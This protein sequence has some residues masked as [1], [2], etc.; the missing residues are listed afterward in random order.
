[1]KAR[2]FTDFFPVA[3]GPAPGCKSRT[4]GPGQ[5][6][7]NAGQGRASIRSFSIAAAKSQ[8]VDHGS[9]AG[10]LSA[11]FSLFHPSRPAGALNTDLTDTGL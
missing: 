9:A 2:K 8:S 10:Q 6:F 7:E 1:V 4:P 11:F 5:R 3:A